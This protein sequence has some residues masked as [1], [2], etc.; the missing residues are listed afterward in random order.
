MSTERFP[1]REGQRAPTADLRVIRDGL[2]ETRNSRELFDGRTVIVFALPGAYTPTCSTAHLPRYNELASTFAA[3]GVDE[4]VCLS[5]ND[6]FVMDAW[7]REQQATNVTLLADG[8]GDFS[9]EMGLLVDKS[10]LGFGARSW[11][12]SMLVRDG[13]IEK[14][15]IEPDRDGDPFDVSDADTMLAYLAPKDGVRPLAVT[16]F[17]KP[18]CGHCVRAKE[19]LRSRGIGF[20]EVG[21]G[22]GVSTSTLRAVSGRSTSPQVFIDGE[23]IGGADE[24]ISFLEAR[25]AAAKKAA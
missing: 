18:G 5:V 9:R 23:A 8:N 13:V 24:L 6:A 3:Q 20:E 25:D 12:Y 2:L 11:R 19:A 4:I 22:K 14:Q 17:T 7:A 1:N 15:F 16:L 10:D 21:L